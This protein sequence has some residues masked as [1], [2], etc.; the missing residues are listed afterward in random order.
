MTKTT[1]TRSADDIAR[2]L[3]AQYASLLADALRRFAAMER[4]RTRASHEV[5]RLEKHLAKIDEFCRTNN[6]A[7]HS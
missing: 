4:Q 2:A 1:S 5:H 3:R 7:T 6:V